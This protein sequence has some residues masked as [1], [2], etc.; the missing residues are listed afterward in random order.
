MKSLHFALAAAAAVALGGATLVSAHAAT[1]AVTVDMKALNGS[2]ESG[3]ATLT[4]QSDG[5]KVVV[6]LKN[7]PAEAQPTHI[8]IGTCG[9][10][11]GAEYALVNVTNGTSTSL[12]G[13]VKLDDLLKG[14]YAINVHKST[15]DLGTYVSCGDIKAS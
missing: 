11:K 8:H 6:T 14:H 3:T 13:G 10:I 15:S 2:G 7:A 4:Q 9:N 12:V 1:T 5:V